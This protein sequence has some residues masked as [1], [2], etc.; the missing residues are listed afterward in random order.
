MS[1]VNR[2]LMLACA[3]A[4]VAQLAAT[5]QTVPSSINYQG[6]LTDSAGQI[7]SDG[8]H[9]MVFKLFD[10][11]QGENE[12]WSSG[13][14]NVTTSG[15]VFSAQLDIGLEPLQLGS[16]WLEVKVGSAPPLPRTPLLSAPFA[17][18][19][20]E[21]PA[22]WNFEGNANTA[23][24]LDYV[25]TS[26][27]TSLEIRVNG[28]RAVRIDPAPVTPSIV[29]GHEVNYADPGVSGAFIGGGGAPE[30]T[31]WEYAVPNRVHDGYGF[32]GGGRNNRVGSADGD[33]AS[34][35]DAVVCGGSFNAAGFELAFVGGGTGNR[36]LARTASVVGGLYNLANGGSSFVGGGDQN[37]A[38]ATW[39]VVVG[40]K[41]NQASGEGAF[42]GGG[43]ENRAIAGNPIEYGAA[44]GGGARNWSRSMCTTVAGGLENEA[45]GW[46]TTIGGGQSNRADAGWATVSGGS[47]N[48][49]TGVWSMI[50]GGESNATEGDYSFA[51]GR[52]AWAIHNG[53]FV[54]ADSTDDRIASTDA[55][56]F[57]ARASG[58]VW[59]YTSGD[60][61]SGAYMSAGDSAWSTVSDRS[62]KENI[63]PVDPKDVLDRLSKVPVST[64]NYRAQGK[65]VRHIGPMAQDFRA[66]FGLGVDDKHISTIDPDGVALAAIQALDRKLKEK[67]AQVEQLQKQL[68][69]LKAALD[70]LKSR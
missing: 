19:A 10:A 35:T 56:Q 67:D 47:T 42:V 16:A 65:S 63:V 32:I 8:S 51:A 28:A 50:P 70:A 52:R 49:A 25:G 31:G 30:D 2:V 39:S 44:I 55:N 62:A 29:G 13:T 23:P 68:D 58:G 6:K 15:G 17:L 40:G 11:S 21:C 26:D 4:W 69:E 27:N 37:Q 61:S 66:A 1:R 24:G 46:F 34:A 57:I 33:P 3:M 43:Y 54:W 36:S 38:N 45:N 60:L 64:W 53:S 48:L 59:F 5:S 7:L 20:G 9:Q 18:R 14:M 22:S 41:E 12:L